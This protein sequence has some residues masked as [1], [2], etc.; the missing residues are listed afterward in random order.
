MNPPPRRH[1]G[2]HCH[3]ERD[4]GGDAEF[5]ALNGGKGEMGKRFWERG[6]EPDCFWVCFGSGE[7]G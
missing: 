5:I 1:P 7:G 4:A 3:T 6:Y 2:P